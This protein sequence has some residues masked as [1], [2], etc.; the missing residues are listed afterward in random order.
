M[1]LTGG[2][3]LGSV[4]IHGTGI[5]F[6]IGDFFFSPRAKI[7]RLHAHTSLSGWTAFPNLLLRKGRLFDTLAFLLSSDQNFLFSKQV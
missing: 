5:Q 2:I 3:D 6:L 4:P 1:G 7:D